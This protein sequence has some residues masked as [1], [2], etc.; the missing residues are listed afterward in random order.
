[1][2]KLRLVIFASMLHDSGSVLN[3]RTPLFDA[4]RSFSELE[5]TYPTLPFK[6]DG[7]KTICFI[8][9]GGTEEMFKQYFNSYNLPRPVVLL[10]DGFHNSLAATFE[11]STFLERRGVDC[12][13][14]NAPLDYNPAYFETLSKKIFGEMPPIVSDDLDSRNTSPY[15][16]KNQ[17]HLIARQRI[18]L[19][20]N[21]SPWLISSGIDR[22]AV[23]KTYGVSFVD[24]PLSEVETRYVLSD[25]D[26]PEIRKIVV[27]MGRFLS[28]G[29]TEDDLKKAAA[30][31]LAIK[32][33]CTENQI[34]ALTIKCFDLLESCR[35]T[36][37]LALSLLNDEGIV[38]GCEGDIPALWTMIY[39]KLALG[40]PAFMANPSS[41]NRAEYTID[42]A[43]CTVPLSM[44]HGF[45]LPSHFESSTGI[46]IAGSIPSGRYSIIKFSGPELDRFYSVKGS[47]IMNTNVPQ[48]CRT[49]IRFKFDSEKDYNGFFTTAKGNHI[50]LVSE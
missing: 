15:I 16:T 32:S 40:K 4:L 31:Y 13:L 18:G 27:S 50:I 48:R 11:I 2:K 9:T 33:I 3:S 10:S 12:C 44:A 41:S 35:T 22:E 30:L 49:Q 24:I 25:Q 34:N 42:F 23:E 38:C 28:D 29:R 26:S 37:C 20:G 5:M 14:L 45:R 21:S 6:D 17:L 8:A 39:A 43:H 7:T 1:M 36:A 46:G 19:F 47:I